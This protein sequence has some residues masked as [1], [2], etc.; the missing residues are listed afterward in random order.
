MGFKY[1]I[2]A[3]IG[4]GRDK[5]CITGKLLLCEHVVKGAFSVS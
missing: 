5:C 4:E 3:L 1:R 2:S